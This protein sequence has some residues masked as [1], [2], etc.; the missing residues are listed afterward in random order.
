[1][2]DLPQVDALATMFGVNKTAVIGS[3]STDLAAA[4]ARGASCRH[5]RSRFERRSD[6]AANR[7]D[8]GHR[9]G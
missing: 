5:A 9:P 2:L 6:V 3:L 4:I 7:R 1:V 8:G